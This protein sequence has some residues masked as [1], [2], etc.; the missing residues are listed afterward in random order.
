MYSQLAPWL[1]DL[2]PGIIS[3]QK[4]VVEENTQLMVLGSDRGIKVLHFCILF[5]DTLPVT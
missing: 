3:W 1:L 4:F 2:W 5:K